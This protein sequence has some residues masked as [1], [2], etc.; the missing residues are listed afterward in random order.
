[1]PPVF[2]PGIS[3][4][5]PLVITRRGQQ[6]RTLAVAQSDHAGLDTQEQPLDDHAPP[7]LS[8]TP[9]FD[10]VSDAGLDF[11][12][13]HT[14]AHALARGQ[15]I[16][17]DDDRQ[18]DHL[19][20]GHGRFNGSEGG[21]HCHRHTGRA[22]YLA[23]EGLAA[24]DSCGR[25]SRSKAWNAGG[26]ES[27]GQPMN[28]RCFGPDNHQ[29]DCLGQGKGDDPFVV[30]EG[31]GGA[32]LGD[33]AHQRIAGSDDDRSTPIARQLPAEGML[34]RPGADHEHPYG[35]HAAR[36]IR[37]RRVVPRSRVWFRSGPTLT[38]VIGAP[39]RFSITSM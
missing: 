20:I 1:M 37:P 31:D 2:G 25:S 38:I 28:Q 11:S 30:I 36:P 34:P 27:V 23:C 24:L 10:Q 32:D 15:A 39:A 21:A 26:R 7:A 6:G 5:E 17:L 18:A 9:L 4:G 22:A 14:D 13:R 8:E 12:Q 35:A 16:G 29:V 3:F 33:V 19:G